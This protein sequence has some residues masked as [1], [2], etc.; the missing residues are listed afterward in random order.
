M[1][2]TMVSRPP[3]APEPARGEYLRCQKWAHSQ[4]HMVLSSRKTTLRIC[5]RW[6]G[7]KVTLCAKPGALCQSQT[8]VEL[9]SI[10]STEDLLHCWDT[11]I[12]PSK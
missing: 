12:N 11:V 8:V 3:L 1:T 9:L 10:C 5:S 6:W 2:S 4:T 7:P